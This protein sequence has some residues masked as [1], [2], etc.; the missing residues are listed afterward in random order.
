MEKPIGIGNSV[1]VMGEKAN[2]FYATIGFK[3]ERGELNSGI[4]YKLGV[5]LGSHLAFHK[6]V[7]YCISNVKTRFIRMGSY[8]H[9]CHVNTY[10]LC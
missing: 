5:E 3:V 1:E 7:R 9:F 6:Q 8:G 4:T 2:R 10:R